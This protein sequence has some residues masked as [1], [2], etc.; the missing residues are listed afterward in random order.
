MIQCFI[1]QHFKQSISKKLILL[2][3][4]FSSLITLVMT[5]L[6]LWLE[7]K[8][9]VNEIET[10]LHDIDKSFSQTIAQQ[11][12]NLDREQMQITANGLFQLPYVDYVMIAGSDMEP[13][14]VG[15]DEKYHELGIDPHIKL[16][17]ELFHDSLETP[18]GKLI[19][20]TSLEPVYQRLRNKVLM[21]LATQG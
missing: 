7:F 18:I 5:G 9:D 12:W 11:I 6:Q 4:L 13:V 3:L 20:S 8:A 19:I 10:R 17:R 15:G 21:T 1:P 14:V 16:S 2:I